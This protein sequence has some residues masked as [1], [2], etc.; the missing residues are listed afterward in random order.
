[1][2][3]TSP[4]GSSAR[5]RI[6]ALAR[7]IPRGRVSTYG[8]LAAMAGCSAR[9][10]GYAMAA[11]SEGTRVPWHRVINSQG[12]ISIPGPEAQALQRQLLERAGILF[13]EDDRIDLK[14][15]VWPD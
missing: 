2:T 10:A 1:M 12:R 11:A 5:Q 8:R 4:A 6:H 13:D 3:M 7:Q 14:Q 9:M 15:Y